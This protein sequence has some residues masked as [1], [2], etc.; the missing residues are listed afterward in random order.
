MEAILEYNSTTPSYDDAVK[1][2]DGFNLIV[3]EAATIVKSSP[4]IEMRKDNILSGALITVMDEW[5]AISQGSD[6]KTVRIFPCDYDMYTT[7]VTL[8]NEK[9]YYIS[10]PAGIVKNSA[11]NLNEKIILRVLGDDGSGVEVVSSSDIFTFIEGNN[12]S[13]ALGAA[14]NC[15]VS[16]Y[17]MSGMMLQNINGSSGTYRQSVV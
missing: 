15:Q 13:V 6:K 5:K 10:I 3:D 8:E 11:G 1:V 17:N 16:I 4:A 12:I 14:D 9:Y 2:F 7:P